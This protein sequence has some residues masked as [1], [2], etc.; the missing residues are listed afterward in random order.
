MDVTNLTWEQIKE[1]VDMAMKNGS[2]FW[3]EMDKE[4]NCSVSIS[5]KQNYTHFIGNRNITQPLVDTTPVSQC[6]APEI[7]PTAKNYHESC[8]EG[9][10]YT[11]IS[12]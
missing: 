9:T 4:G 3:L 11:Y 12:F 2:D 1:L 10:D 7:T 6:T 8:A 5:G